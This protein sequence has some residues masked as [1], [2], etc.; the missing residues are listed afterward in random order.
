[1]KKKVFWLVLLVFL[2][3]VTNT[4]G[5]VH[6]ADIFLV[7]ANPTPTDSLIIKAVFGFPD[8]CHFATEGMLW[9]YPQVL[10]DTICSDTT[11]K[12]YLLQVNHLYEPYEPCPAAVRWDTVSFSL[13]QL[14]LGEYWVDLLVVYYDMSWLPKV[15]T[16]DTIFTFSIT[17]TKVNEEQ[18]SVPG[19]FELSQNY[20][21][22]FNPSTTIAYLVETDGRVNLSIYNLLGQKVRELVNEKKEKGNYSVQWDGKNDKGERLANGVYFYV[23]KAGESISS[24][25]MILLK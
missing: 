25:K 13:G 6:I 14:T 9:K 15:A 3:T 8:Y 17:P 16:Y 7:P 1:M 18:I 2:I 23:L 21:N 19:K 10:R 5:A 20:P 22:P 11:C 4:L 12:Y 24:K